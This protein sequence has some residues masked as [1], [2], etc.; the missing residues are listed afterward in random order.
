MATVLVLNDTMYSANLGD[1]K[2]ILCRRSQE[3][4]LSFVP[5][6][7]DHN[8][9]NVSESGR[10]PVWLTVPLTKDHNPSNVSKSGRDPV[11]LLSPSQKITTLP[12]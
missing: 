9:S 6:T 1:S 2:A 12:M 11:R 4:K 3:G 5:L 7:K 8:P 10:D